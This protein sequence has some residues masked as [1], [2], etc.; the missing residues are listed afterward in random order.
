MFIYSEL[1][2]DGPYIYLRGYENS[3]IFIQSNLSVH[4]FQ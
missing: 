4:L 3:R 1:R 2:P